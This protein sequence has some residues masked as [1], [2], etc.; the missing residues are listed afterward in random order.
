M[1]PNNNR[2]VITS[3]ELTSAIYVMWILLFYASLMLI[4]NKDTLDFALV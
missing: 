4:A 1:K 3:S 2:H